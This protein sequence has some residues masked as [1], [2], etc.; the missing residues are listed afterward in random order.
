MFESHKTL[1]TAWDIAGVHPWPTA[2]MR[3]DMEAAFKPG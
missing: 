3:G 2:A 1:R